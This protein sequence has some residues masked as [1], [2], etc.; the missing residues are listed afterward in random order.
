M[1]KT[2]H[3]YLLLSVLS[4]SSCFSQKKATKEQTKEATQ[5]FDHFAFIDAREIYKEL[6]NKGNRSASLLMKLGDSYYY[7]NDLNNALE[8]YSELI[9]KYSGND[10][11]AEYLFRYA[12]TLRS[13][14]LYQKSEEIM[15]AFYKRKGIKNNKKQNLNEIL[16]RKNKSII[17]DNF[18]YNSIFSDYAPRLYN[19]SNSLLFVSARDTIDSKVHE[20]NN[21]PFSNLYKIE[22]DQVGKI[23]GAVNSKYHESTAVYTQNKD[24]LYFTRNNY[25]KKKKKKSSTGIIMLKLYR[26]TSK[27]GGHLN[28]IEELPFNN[29]NYSVAHPYLSNDGKKLFFTSDMPGGFGMSDLYV[30]NIEKDGKFGE[31]TNLGE[32]INTSGRETFPSLD[33]NDNLFFASDGYLGLGGL[34]IFMSKYD[35]KEGYSTV[36][37]L[38]APINTP[39]DDF[40]FTYNNHK[41][42]GYFA[43][44]RSGGVGSDDIY[45]FHKTGKSSLSCSN[46]IK[47]TVFSSNAHHKIPNARLTLYHNDEAVETISSDRNGYYQF[48]VDC[49]GK[50]FI[51]IDKE[52]FLSTEIVVENSKNYKE[53]IF[54]KRGSLLNRINLKYGDDLKSKLQLEKIY[55]EYNKYTVQKESKI[56]LQKIIL[57]LNKFPNSKIKLQ[58][59]TDSR[60]SIAYNKKLSLKRAESVKRYMVNAGISKNRIQV[61]GFGELRPIIDCKDHCTKENHQKNRRCEFILF[62]GYHTSQLTRI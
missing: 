55:F 39:Y 38:G 4:Y 61:Y 18:D 41:K 6:I 54:L 12:H 19:N 13:M 3:L 60:G 9:T 30:V 14:K 31:V 56:E 33:D 35:K 28:Y 29:D 27:N 34:D 48:D 24:T 52:D 23:E 46:R 50:Y 57:F 7:N 26:A 42:T 58:A 44:N 25:Y 15:A 32:K 22:E 47:G 51:R 45:K 8:W 21:Q 17:L 5:K 49:F 53:D 2:I 37:N 11:E 1:M 59:H 16:K 36:Y 40:S 43:S 62:K 10:Y 20:W